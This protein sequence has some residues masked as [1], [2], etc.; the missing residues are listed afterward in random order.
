MADKYLFQANFRA[1]AS[2]VFAPENRWGYFPAFSVGWKLNE[3]NFI[4]DN[5]QFISLLKLRAGWGKS[6]SD[7]IPPY[8]YSSLIYSFNPDYIFGSDSCY[9]SCNNITLWNPEMKWETSTT[10]NIGLDL[11]VFQNQLQFTFDLFY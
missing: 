4:K 9:R 7:L 10:S 8:G 1:D 3:E 2:Y 11:S 5:A 6:G